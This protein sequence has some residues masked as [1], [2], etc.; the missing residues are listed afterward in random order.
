MLRKHWDRSGRKVVAKDNL[1]ET[2]FASP[3]YQWS[4]SGRDQFCQKGINMAA[5][6]SVYAAQCSN[7]PN[8][9]TASQG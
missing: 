1:Y 2:V 6:S 5:E 3:P 9:V 7:K 4:S 8:H